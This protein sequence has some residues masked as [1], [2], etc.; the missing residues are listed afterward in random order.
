MYT[1][2]EKV[3]PIYIE[4]EMRDAYI[5][6]AMSV[7]VGRALP[8]VRDGL[9]PVHR[10]ILYAMKDMGI[11]H[12]KP[13]KKCARIVGE[14][15]GKYHPHGDSAVYD[16]LVRMVQEFSLRYPLVN[17][18]GNFGSVDG[19]PAAAMRY[20]E[21][22]LHSITTPILQDLEKETVDWEPNFDG[23][24]QEPKVLPTILPVLLLNGSSGIAVGMATNIPPHNL[25]EIVD[26]LCYVIDHPSCKVEDL[27][28]I[29]KGP[30]FP[31]GAMICGTDGIVSAYKTGRGSLK[32][33]ARAHVEQKKQGK[34][35]IVVTEIPYQVSKS[36]LI[37]TIADLVKDK[38]MDGIT[39]IRDESDKDGMRIV[40]EIRRGCNTEVVLNQLYKHTQMQETFGVIML[41]IVNGQPKILNLKE[42]LDHFIA[43]RKEVVIRRTKYDLA[44]AEER[45]HILEGLKIAIKNLD[46]VI[47]TIK[48][49]K[50]PDAAKEALIKKFD[51]SEIQALAILAM[52]LQQL[53]NL[54]TTK[55]ED[56]YKELIKLIETLQGI[57]ASEKKILD[58][59]KKES[60]EMKEK[61]G[62]A[63]R[64][65]ITSEIGDINVEDLIA[66]ED[67]VVTISHTGYI[68]RF[69]VSAY[70]QQKRGGKGVTGAEMKEE[71]FIEHL[72]VASTHD[73]MLIFTNKG[74]VH[75][76]KVHE[77]PQAGRRTKGRPIVN[78]LEL[79]EG[80]QTTAFVPVREFKEGQYVVMATENGTIKKTDLSLFSN[81]RKGG[82][83]AITLDKNDK[84]IGSIL[85][86]GKDEICLATKMGKS[87]RFKEDKIRSMGRSA[88]GV[89]GI[90]LKKGDSVVGMVKVEK[91]G[92]ILTVCEKGYGKR[93]EFS[94]YRLQSRGGSGIINIK[95]VDKNGPV[96]GIKTVRE[97]DEIML[98]SKSGMVV[99]IAVK[100]IS[101][102]GRATQGV[103]LIS[104]KPGDKLTSVAM[105][106]KEDDKEE[107]EEPKTTGTEEQN[108]SEEQE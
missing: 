17:G 22:R 26:A 80:E 104:L 35:D 65:E 30:D 39:D 79:E 68:K 44:K 99:R 74:K 66:E 86:D 57:L 103:R 67:M 90:S 93:T 78:L 5:N 33:H 89:R 34:E 61:F 55:I 52:K 23:S 36:R 31:T 54:E 47:A 45:A 70:R 102:I 8:D 82:I 87:I 12:T 2:N 85:S 108:G 51:L 15:L 100:D 91:E 25:N 21:A 38:K 63:R 13:Y 94:V 27:L 62:D 75:W 59:I 16:A 50:D 41:A 20:T 64:T 10:R 98:I 58:I 37:T 107:G 106:E 88:Q 69:P 72:F 3:M 84:L 92:T 4:E 29:V 43:H 32:V 14:V 6:Y 73:Y 95:I 42:M 9:K 1:R 53:T 60:L 28:K 24:L 18:Q 81:P 56:E 71:D 11:V 105:V 101:E 97:E 46:E 48:K 19:D 7:I 49:S 77:L 40:F 83:I 96:V 76:I